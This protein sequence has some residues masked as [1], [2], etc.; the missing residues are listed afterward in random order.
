MTTTSHFFSDAIFFF[1]LLNLFYANQASGLLDHDCAGMN[2]LSVTRWRAEAL[3]SAL[4]LL[5][6]S[7]RTKVRW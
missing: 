3:T 4:R 6:L 7:H 1:A 2:N 5:F